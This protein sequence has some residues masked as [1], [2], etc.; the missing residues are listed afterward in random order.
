MSP[1]IPPTLATPPRE[2]ARGIVALSLAILVLQIA[3]TRLLSVV[4]WYHFAFVAISL[5]MLGLAL[6]GIGLFLQ[7]RLLAAT[8]RLLPWY[9]RGAGVTM[10]A[11]LVFVLFAAPSSDGSGMLAGDIVL[12]YLVLLVPFTLAGFAVSALLSFHARH[13]GPLYARDLV[14]AGIGCLA[15]VPMLDLGGAP[16]AILGGVALLFASGA[17]LAPGRA[18]WLDIALL[19]ATL[20]LIAA[21]ATTRLLEPDAMHGIPDGDPAN[22]RPCEYA[23]WNSHSRIVVTKDSDWGKVINIDGHATTGMYRFDRTATQQA[24][25][26]QLPWM[27][28]RAGSMPYVA[29]GPDSKPSVLLIGPGGG[30]DLLNGI[31]FGADITGVELNGLIHG[32]MTTSP[33]AEYSGHVYSAPGVNV[34][35]DEAR[36]WVRRSDR[37]FDL[38]QAS[39]IDTWAATA[40]GAF[41]LA[42]NALYTV[43]AFLDYR[44][45]LSERGLV[46]FMR[47]HED[48]PRQSLRLLALVAE[49]MDR[50]GDREPTRHVVAIEE[51]MF[52]NPGP[53][54]ASVLWSR[55][56]FSPEALARLRAAIDE[57]TKIA[58][59]RV[60]CWP[61]EVH[62]ND[63]SRFL[64]AEDRAAF[65]AGHRF[66]VSATTD[67]RPFFFHTLRFGDLIQAGPASAQNEEAVQVLSTVLLTVLAIT[68]LAFVLPM[69][70]TLRVASLGGRG[71][72][73][74]RLGYFCCLGIGFMLVEIPLLQR[75]GLYM[76]HPTWSLSTVLGTLLVGAGIGG[77]RTARVGD[78]DVPAAATRALVVILGAL[79]VTTVATPWLLTATLRWPFVARAA[80]TAAVMAPL[81]HCLGQALPLG[82]RLLN[83]HCRE[84][85]PWAWGLNGAAS[86]LAS[87]LAV[88]IG[89]QAGFTA[90]LAIGLGCYLIALLT[91]RRLA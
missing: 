53:P 1:P 35:H 86:V 34:V 54:M 67:D 89:M 57:R 65:L 10:L 2:V 30:L 32:L 80:L 61:G 88:A 21:N 48:P 8:P 70:W 18:R 90:A 26:E 91:V 43:E 63:L 17:L 12:L 40:G 60:L 75:F 49:A 46:H 82:I 56:A 68:V 13:I 36:S 58:P 24:V 52:P 23:G 28:L 81:G 85:V 45:H 72:T 25:R 71:R 41:A 73:A 29:L 31:W 6:A 64:R 11:A 16:G 66:E 77:M 15:V 9:C 78:D 87:I 69:L 39:M 62:D 20:G 79:L 27:A 44:E 83:Q 7:P 37:R 38:I 33:F 76:G 51:P 47:W 4:L 55:Q 22:G 3:L 59:V 5:A 14:G 50:A 84:L 42:E 74:V 19:V